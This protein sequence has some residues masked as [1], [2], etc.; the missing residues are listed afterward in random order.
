MKDYEVRVYKSGRDMRL[1][2]AVVAVECDE[3]ATQYMLDAT[4][5][6]R[7]KESAQ[8]IGAGLYTLG[9]IVPLLYIPGAYFLGQ[10]EESRQ[11]SWAATVD[12]INR[13]DYSSSRP[14]RTQT[15]PGSGMEM[16]T[17]IGRQQTEQS[18]T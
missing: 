13:R 17:S 2:A 5:H 14:T 7:E 6:R 15:T 12:S 8:L 16:V 11:E 10:A 18:S 4:T 3:S 1:P 9:V